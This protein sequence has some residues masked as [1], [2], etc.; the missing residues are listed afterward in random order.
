MENPDVFRRTVL[1][2]LAVKETSL[3]KTCPVRQVKEIKL[4]TKK[5]AFF[6]FFFFSA[7][8]ILYRSFKRVS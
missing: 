5:K 3:P 4:K 1:T 2:N 6:F 7:L 8:F